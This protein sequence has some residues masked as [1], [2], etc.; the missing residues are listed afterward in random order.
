MRDVYLLRYLSDIIK[1]KLQQKHNM[2]LEIIDTF[3][4]EIEE[5]KKI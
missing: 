1:A 2:V 4:D 5:H 3:Y